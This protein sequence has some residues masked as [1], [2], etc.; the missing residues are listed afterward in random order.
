MEDGRGYGE[1]KGDE[2]RMKNNEQSIAFLLSNDAS[3]IDDSALYH[4]IPL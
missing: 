3:M 2:K 4:Q 1:D